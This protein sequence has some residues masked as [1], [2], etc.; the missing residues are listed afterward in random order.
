[1]EEN[2]K[3]EDKVKKLE[4][5]FSSLHLVTQVEKFGTPQV[6]IYVILLMV[7]RVDGSRNLRGFCSILE[8]DTV[9]LGRS[10]ALLFM[11]FYLVSYWIGS[12]V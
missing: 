11:G 7:K 2:E 5:K 3:L 1:M 12:T 4:A 6:C 10:F 8:L 9:C